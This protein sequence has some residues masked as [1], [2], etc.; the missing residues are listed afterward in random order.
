MGR[1]YGVICALWSLAVWPIIANSQ[2]PG[3]VTGSLTHWYR[4]DAFNPATPDNTSLS[5][6]TDQSGSGNNCSQTGALFRRPLYRSAQV[7]GNPAIEFDGGTRFFDLNLVPTYGSNFTVITVVRRYN[8]G[9]NQFFLGSRTASPNPTLSIGYMAAP[10]LRFAEYGTI[11]QSSTLAFS[12]GI[13]PSI[14]IAEFSTTSG[15]RITDVVDGIAY[16]ATNATTTN[17]AATAD[18]WMGRGNSGTGMSGQIA[19]MIIY[20]RVLSAAELRQVQTYLSVKYGLSIPVAE[21]TFFTDAT[22]ANDLAAI[23]RDLLVSG[24]NQTTSSSENPD[25]MLEISNP[26]SLDNGDYLCLG[27]N[28]GS[29][30][31]TAYGGTN[32]TISSTL[33]REWKA[34]VVNNPGTVTLR[35]NLTGITGYSASNLVLLVDN[36]G[37]GYD[38]D[39]PITGTFSSPFI[40]FNNVNVQHGARLR[41]AQ[42]VDKWYAVTS[43]NSSGAIWAPTPTGTPQTIGTFCSRV[44]LE[45]NAGVIV[46]ND[47]ALVCRHLVVNPNA[48]FNS[49]SSNVEIHGDLTVNGNFD[50]SLGSYYFNGTTPQNISGS[51]D[52]TFNNLYSNNALSLSVFSNSLSIARL[53][54]VNAGIFYTNNLVTLLS[55]P[56]LTASIG[57]L[58]SGDINGRITYQRYVRPSI[59]GWVQICSPIQNM[60]LA[61]WND[62]I[63]TTGFPGSQFPSY[64]FNNISWYNETLP[65]SRNTGYVPATN[66]TD[67]IRNNAGYF[68][69]MNA[70]PVTID[71]TGNINKGTQVLPVTFTNT[72]N[73]SADGWCLVANP[74]CSSIDWDATAWAKTNMTNAVYIWNAAVNQFAAYVG[75]IGTNGGSRFIASGQS[76]FVQANGASPLLAVGENAKT[77]NN[78]A[79]RSEHLASHT[80]TLQLDGMNM[81]DEFS[82][83]HRDGATPAFDAA[84]DAYKLRSPVEHWM[85]MS[86]LDE[87]GDDLSISSIDRSTG[88]TQMRVKIEVPAHGDYTLN[89]SGLE[90]FAKGACLYL[91]NTHTGETIALREGSSAELHLEGNTTHHFILHIGA[92]VL[93][94][95]K[96]ESC[97]GAHDGSA[98]IVAHTTVQWKNETGEVFHTSHASQMAETLTAL[99]AGH[100][101]LEST[102]NPVCGT[103]IYSFHIGAPSELQATATV[104]HPTLPGANDG[105]IQ[106]QLNGGIGDIKWKWDSGETTTHLDELSA[107]HYSGTAIDQMGC[108]RSFTFE[109]KNA[110][111]LEETVT[112]GRITFNDAVRFNAHWT[113]G[114]LNVKL[115]QAA[116]S[117]QIITVT[118]AAGRMLHKAYISEG[119]T[120]YTVPMQCPDQVLIISLTDEQGASA[121][122][123]RVMRQ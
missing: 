111:A 100:Y 2:T 44:S 74:F 80:L 13:A 34:A 30:N 23:G 58:T 114:Q 62:D 83:V 4:A 15:K 71:L 26:S 103:V 35:F 113:E 53:L 69:Y 47:V 1:F 64:N 92:P 9:T 118:D 16:R 68:V 59:G 98:T 42:H 12:T 14:A 17:F 56:T 78:T 88:A 72:G 33:A 25:D 123:L 93:R 104:Q 122:S 102:H 67:A 94:T 117:E 51:K 39:T 121:G 8:G 18:G 48:T 55:S 28:N 86:V 52:V 54:Q 61:D 40:T 31:F 37:N 79:F 73:A 107:G 76:F 19:E 95:V 27:N 116:I 66:I 21:H 70:A 41:L 36:N 49:G 20:T 7:N 110:E 50:A 105:A 81:H 85:Y 99:N 22:Y 106:V 91:E 60:S 24:L 3:G 57:P 89:T 45:I 108:E 5:S 43:G 65:G 87:N 101:T 6:W 96:D 29:R 46:S 77:N 84:F 38:D 11:A 75:G 63:I 32:C 119:T 10:G 82:I 120:Q 115:P 112:P 90:A 109:L 97:F